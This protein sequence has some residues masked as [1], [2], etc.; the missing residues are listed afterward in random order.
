VDVRLRDPCTH[1]RAQGPSFRAERAGDQ[2]TVGRRVHGDSEL[3]RKSA[4]RISAIAFKFGSLEKA[5]SLDAIQAML[6][7]EN[8]YR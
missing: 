2:I 8:E 3:K 5:H 1:K 6:P 7:A 4:D